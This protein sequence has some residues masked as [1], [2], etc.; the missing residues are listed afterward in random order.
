MSCVVSTVHS[1]SISISSPPPYDNPIIMTFINISIATTIIIII[2]IFLNT[3][4]QVCG[5]RESLY[6][7]HLRAKQCHY[8]RP[9]DITTG[10]GF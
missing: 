6:S 4:T 5:C 1:S 3:V 2:V 7:H 9:T 10:K 8:N